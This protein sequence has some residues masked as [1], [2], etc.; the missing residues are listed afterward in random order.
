M[1]TATTTWVLNISENIIPKFKS[2][3]TEGKNAGEKIKG[4][5]DKAGESVEKTKKKVDNL[6]DSFR[7]MKPMDWNA[8]SQGFQSLGNQMEKLKG[9]GASFDAG[10]HELKGLTGAT[11]EQMD[12]MT[13]SARGLSKEFGT[14]GADQ[15]ASYQGILGKLGPGI[16]ENDAALA[17]MGKSVS[18][19]S[20]T[21]KGDMAGAND[22]LTNALIQFKVNL[23]DPMEAATEMDRMM[24]VMAA[25]ARAGSVEVP[26]I[27]KALS[28]V[29]GVA[30]MSNLSF[31]E[32][33]AL[34]QGMAKGG[35]EVG[36]LGVAS[37]NAL[38]K[39]AAPATLSDDASKYLQAY[40]V[41]IQKI[42]DTTIPFAERLKELSK[43][44]HDM[45]ALALVFGTENVQGAQAM[46][47]TIEYQKDLT[48]QV[49]G[50][51][52]AYVMAK[53]N[54]ES[55]NERMKRYAA[56]I[57][58]FKVGIF[59]AIAPVTAL[60]EAGT[61]MLSTGS[62]L[63]NIYSGIGPLMK[64][65]GKW[66]KNAAIGQKLLSVWT[67]IST[68]AQTAW[69]R[70]INW[71]PI[72]NFVTWI[73]NS[74]LAQKLSSAWTAVATAAQWAWNAALTANPIGLIIV[75]IAALIAVVAVAIKYYDQWGAA[76]LLFMGPVGQVISAF[77]S[78]YDHWDSIKK[79]FQTEGILG[80]LKRIGVVLLD[81]L[82]KPLQQISGWIDQIFGTDLEAGFKGLRK[83]MDLLNDSEKAQEKANAPKTLSEKQKI[84]QALKNGKLVMYNGKAVLPSSRDKWEKEKKAKEEKSKE[85][86]PKL[87]SPDSVL[88]GDK[89]K[90]EKKKKGK[91]EGSDD[92]TTAGGNGAG[93]KTINV[94]VEMHNHFS[95]DKSY[96]SVDNIANRVVGKINDR[97]RDAIVAID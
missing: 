45:N 42:S 39:M 75:G 78:I 51:K 49:T 93:V 56:N 60:T 52:D 90:K 10:M 59:D 94:R 44:G 28:E 85:K 76:L 57:E 5:F 25:S 12:L 81:V 95:V 40:G 55:W 15:L 34:L 83:N 21:M 47:S 97:L 26:E 58:D 32:T 11:A 37:R 74:A 50:T 14:S 54:M 48:T 6:F 82:L 67:G 91:G 33:N 29:G 19:M 22:A 36:K 71:A 13:K 8:M 79:A 4:S 62:D 3:Q 69:N 35:V 61:E 63:A 7:K 84:D 92:T 20:K 72:K 18:V 24:N 66:L 87:L 80:G 77:K 73:R 31:E 46:L 88:G 16:A 64:D 70:T 2:L 43:I 68:F 96:G 1:S 53:E 9:P 38:L 27:S 30:K 86:P 23:E 89:E 17:S 41:D 65:F